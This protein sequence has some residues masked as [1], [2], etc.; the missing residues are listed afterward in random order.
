MESATIASVCRE[1]GIACVILRAISDVAG[2]DLPLDF[3]VLMTAEQTLS[4]AKLLLAVLRAPHRIPALLR[5]GR[6]SAL[7]ARQ[8]ADVL[9][10]TI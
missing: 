8:L 7:A 9:A 3:N 10:A 4:P 2:E 5:L 1:M 6:N